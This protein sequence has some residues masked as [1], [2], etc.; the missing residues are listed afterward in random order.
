M[1]YDVAPWTFTGCAGVREGG[2]GGGARVAVTE[3]DI[4]EALHAQKTG[5]LAG[6]AEA[7]KRI[8]FDF[9]EGVIVLNRRQFM[10]VIMNR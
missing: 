7:L 10:P 3:G 2:P 6:M 8:V 1:V 4:L 5:P 9:S